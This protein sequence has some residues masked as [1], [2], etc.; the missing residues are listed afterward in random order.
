M[1]KWATETSKL[2][3]A[4]VAKPKT[5]EYSDDDWTKHIEHAKGVGTSSE[6]ALATTAA[7]PGLAPEK[8]V[9]VMDALLVANPK[10][11]YLGLA[12]GAYLAALAKTGGVDKQIEG[13]NKIV[14]D[15]PNQEDALMSLSDG[16]MGKNRPDQAYTYATRLATT[17]KS[18]AKPEGFSDE[19]WNR[20][21]SFLLSHAYYD[22]GIT[23]CMRQVWKDCAIRICAPRFP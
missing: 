15:N 11:T 17:M 23:G 18:K 8:V 21:K 5:G 19:E 16:L 10:S 13:A 22:A 9:E 12:A 14:K 2:A 4:E 20:R 7:Q 1:K 6:Y 3:K